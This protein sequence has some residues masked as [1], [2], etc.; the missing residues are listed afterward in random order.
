ME[1]YKESYEEWSKKAGDLEGVIK[2]LEVNFFL[3][4]IIN[5]FIN[6]YLTFLAELRFVIYLLV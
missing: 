5:Y 1:L 2:A 3:L 6:Y 4:V